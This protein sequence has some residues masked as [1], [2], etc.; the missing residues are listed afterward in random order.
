MY[1]VKN[2]KVRNNVLY[3]N[4]D[5]Q[6]SP[7]PR[8]CRLSKYLYQNTLKFMKVINDKLP[9]HDIDCTGYSQLPI[10]VKS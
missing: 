1:C 4:T 10:T 5:K 6:G 2:T 9:S 8:M 3:V 7:M